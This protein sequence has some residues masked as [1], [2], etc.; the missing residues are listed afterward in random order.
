VKLRI[1]KRAQ[2]QADKIEEWWVEHRPAAPTL[3]TDE[4]ERT[5]RYLCQMRS[6]GIRWPTPRRPMLRRILMPRT[7][8][9][10][11]FLVDE[12]TEVVHVLAIWGAPK[13]RTPKL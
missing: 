2:K 7:E 6:A 9:H 4:L 5:F 11:Y 10:V 3:F 8:N 13:G 12:K 1:G